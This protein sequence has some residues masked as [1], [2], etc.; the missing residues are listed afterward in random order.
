MHL[1]GVLLF[2]AAALRAAA[3]PTSSRVLHEKRQFAPL[4]WEKRDRVDATIVLPVR[5]GLT[6]R[7]L[8]L[9]PDLLNE[10]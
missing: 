9:G 7:N 2:L 4:H 1:F 8:D 3:A 6:Q 5:I 10:V